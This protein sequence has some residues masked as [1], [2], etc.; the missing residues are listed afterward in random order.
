[1]SSLI[2]GPKSI[3]SGPPGEICTI[4]K[5]KATTKIIRKNAIINFFP[6]YFS[7]DKVYTPV[8][9]FNPERIIF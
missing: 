3:A 5:F 8:S 1:M 2:L 4:V 7:K 6:I 9:F